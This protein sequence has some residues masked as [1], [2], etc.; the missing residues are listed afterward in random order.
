MLLGRSIVRGILR[1]RTHVPVL[2]VSNLMDSFVHALIR[3]GL[4]LRQTLH[5]PGTTSRVPNVTALP[6]ALALS[7]PPSFH[8]RTSHF[9]FLSPCVCVT[10]RL[11]SLTS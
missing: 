8:H 9:T 10:Y 6:C 1:R 5:P 2:K 3:E 4:V 11:P 7:T